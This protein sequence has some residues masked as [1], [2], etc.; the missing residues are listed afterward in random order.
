M[1]TK[2]NSKFLSSI[3]SLKKKNGK[4]FLLW[5]LI[6]RNYFDYFLMRQITVFVQAHFKWN[7]SILIVDVMCIDPMLVIKEN[8]E[9]M[10]LFSRRI[11]VLGMFF[12][13]VKNRKTWYEYIFKKQKCHSKFITLIHWNIS[14]EIYLQKT[15]EI[16]LELFPFRWPHCQNNGWH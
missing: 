1:K 11:V 10:L 4:Y 14:K 13:R 16:Y 7:D 3:C 6:N 5:L 15:T 12:L 9:M 2:I 8:S